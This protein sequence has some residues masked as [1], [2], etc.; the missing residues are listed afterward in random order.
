MDPAEGSAG[1]AAPAATT[2]SLGAE[3]TIRS[4]VPPP[5]ASTPATPAVV[6]SLAAPAADIPDTIAQ[7]QR[8]ILEMQASRMADKRQQQEEMRALQDGLEHAEL[9]LAEREAENK[10]LRKVLR[11]AARKEQARAAGGVHNPFLDAE[12]RGV[13]NFPHFDSLNRSTES[14]KSTAVVALVSAEATAGTM[15]DNA[16]DGGADEEGDEHDESGDSFAPL[17]LSI[18]GLAH[19]H[20]LQDFGVQ[21]PRSELLDSSQAIA[22][23]RTP[24]RIIAAGDVGNAV[25]EQRG[26]QVGTGLDALSDDGEEERAPGSPA[27]ADVYQKILAAGQA[28]ESLAAATS[29]ARPQEGSGTPQVAGGGSGGGGMMTSPMTMSFQTPQSSHRR[30]GGG[31]GGGGR[32]TAGKH[33]QTMAT[34]GLSPIQGSLAGELSHTVGNRGRVGGLSGIGMRVD[35]ESNDMVEV[36][37]RSFQSQDSG[38]GGHSRNLAAKVG[39]A[40]TSAGSAGSGGRGITRLQQKL[41]GMTKEIDEDVRS[42]MSASRMDSNDD[43]LKMFSTLKT[44]RPSMLSDSVSMLE[45]F[46]PLETPQVTP[47]KTVAAA[48]RQQPPAPDF[49]SAIS[50][51]LRQSQRNVHASSQHPADRVGASTTPSTAATATPFMTAPSTNRH[52]S[53]SELIQEG[54][55]RDS[56]SGE[57]LPS[58]L[59]TPYVIAAAEGQFLQQQQQQQS[60]RQTPNQHYMSHA[61]HGDHSNNNNSSSSSHNNNSRNGNG[62]GSGGAGRMSQSSSANPLNSSTMWAQASTLTGTRRK[63]NEPNL[64]AALWEAKRLGITSISTQLEYA[65]TILHGTS[66]GLRPSSASVASMRLSQQQKQQQQQ[67][68]I[69]L[70]G[71]SRI[72]S[73]GSGEQSTAGGG[74]EGETGPHRTA[75][76]A[77][78]AGISMFVRPGADGSVPAGNVAAQ[79]GGASVG[80]ATGFASGMGGISAM[81][82]SATLGGQGAEILPSTDGHFRGAFSGLPP[83]RGETELPGWYARPESSS[84]FPRLDSL[85]DFTPMKLD[86]GLAQFSSKYWAKKLG[87]NSPTTRRR[88]GVPGSPNDTS[89]PQGSVQEYQYR[90]PLSA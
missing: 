19:F 38:I 88:L 67:Q 50:N 12:D 30:V 82:K 86:P 89:S 61:Y 77:P 36:S 15:E 40:N 45:P 24:A 48:I 34:P 32:S 56:L 20:G 5:A 80:E 42:E 59:P 55:L 37:E 35:R 33:L 58:P 60:S 69:M 44:P 52:L 16:E 68:G 57:R 23:L 49:V 85:F 10:K 78:P 83:R 31:A 54:G 90:S 18:G 62:G 21:P 73:N 46:S 64:G 26:G 3:Y 1:R 8:K 22:E 75:S 72:G 74:L 29:P 71:Y 66:R 65:R 4:A 9:R 84:T 76:A 51:S 11:D 14:S 17:N 2:Y 27:M 81:G 63:R 25:G 41:S 43:S 28:D 53:M 47:A 6:P 39:A 79:N 87:M 7:L 70:N 13:Q